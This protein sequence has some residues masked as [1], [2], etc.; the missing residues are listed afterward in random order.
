[1]TTNKQEYKYEDN[2]QAILPNHIIHL[3]GDEW[4]L[5]RW[6]GLRSAGFPT[7][8]LCALSSSA[9]ATAADNVL[10]LESLA[11]EAHAKL[12]T[13][14]EQKLAGRQCPQIQRIIRRL[15][16]GQHSNM[17]IAQGIESALATFQAARGAAS[18]AHADFETTFAAD[19]VCAMQTLRQLARDPL[20][21]EALLWQNRHALHNGVDVLLS[22]SLDNRSFKQRQR[23]ALITAYLQRYCTKNDTIGFF[24]P[25][26]WAHIVDQGPFLKAEPGPGLLATRTVYFEEWCIDA[27]AET[28]A[29]DE[30]L[31][32]WL[33]PRRMPFVYVEGTSLHLPLTPPISLSLVEAAVLRSCD[34]ERTA[35]QLAMDLLKTGTPGLRSSADVYEVLR[36]L[37]A[38]K[39]IAWRLEVPIE[40]LYPERCLRQRLACIED[41]RLRMA[42][43][44]ALAELEASK[45][46]VERAAG[47]V[48]QLDKAMEHLETTFTK[49][50]D[51]NATRRAGKFYAG[52]S[53]VYEDCRRDVTVELGPALLST[54][55]PPLTLLLTSARWFTFEA[56]TLYRTAFK[57]IYDELVSTTSVTRAPEIPLS[58]FWLYTHSLLFDQHHPL[59]TT[60]KR[61]LQERW[62]R[63]LAIPADQRQV[64]YQTEALRQQVEETFAVPHPGWPSAC[65]HSPD[66]MIAAASPEAIL[67]GEFHYVLG[68]IHPGANTLQ[69]AFFAAQHPQRHELLQGIRADRTEAQVVLVPS[70]ELGGATARMSNGFVLPEDW[71]FV[72]A[73][74]SCDVPTSRAV[75]IGALV[76]VRVRDELVVHTRDGGPLWDIMDVLGE[77]MMLQTLHLFDILPSSRHTP[78]ITFD[79]LIVCREAWRF[80]P[81]ECEFASIEQ[82]AE[83]FLE[84]RRWMHKQNLPH[85]LFVKTPI[86]R[87]PLYVDFDSLLSV[88]VLARMV[89]RAMHTNEVEGEIAFTEMLP[90]LHECW[91]QDRQQQHYTSEFRIVAVDRRANATRPLALAEVNKVSQHSAL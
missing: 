49:I 50:T 54:L 61:D 30:A 75:P 62:G 40:N 3:N 86:E 82:E 21:R 1:L 37:L 84:A 24:G 16:Q 35:Y 13:A 44:A 77:F 78:R 79:R 90:D 38:K 25:V 43:L 4:A 27:L 73:H 34:G 14:L 32:P 74:D 11:Y 68:E 15:E 71:R 64:T 26:G 41:E 5:W 51:T 53:L 42:A 2:H 87:K 18:A 65:Y 55:G 7:E 23:E 60:L 47:N 31:Q 46:A 33:V 17:E 59:L 88:D 36:C 20:F 81:H 85:H 6:V 39:R 83:R 80:N 67:N 91:L 12:F 76:V 22:K 69:S 89:R 48:E 45:E 72:F 8:K 52:R 66:V 56:A 57:N 63:I 58:N 9:S 19:V 28:L 29:K 70:K 10:V